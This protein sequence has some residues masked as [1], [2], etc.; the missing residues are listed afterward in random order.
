MLRKT[1]MQCVWGMAWVLPVT[2][3]AAILPLEEVLQTVRTQYPPLL[4]AWLQQDVQSGR[5]RQAA[6]A[7]DPTLLA[8]LNF[9]PL[10]YYEGA[11]V[12]FLVDQPLL[13]G[14]SVYAG[15]RVSTGTFASYERKDRTSPSGKRSLVLE[16]LYG[17]IG[18]SMLVGP[19][20]DKQRWTV[21]WQIR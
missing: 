5:V 6:G 17:A 12:S 18:R 10:D 16:F 11:N 21:S 19:I 1:I 3:Q 13:S 2:L 7:F 9:R 15:Y 8:T 20:L 14:G 4:A